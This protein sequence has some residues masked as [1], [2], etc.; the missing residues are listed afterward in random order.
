MEQHI[1][2]LQELKKYGVE[3][4]FRVREAERRPE[5]IT[6]VLDKIAS[7]QGHAGSGP[8]IEK[9]HTM[10]PSRPGGCERVDP[11]GIGA[12]A[13][14]FVPNQPRRR[15]QLFG[16]MEVSAGTKPGQHQAQRVCSHTQL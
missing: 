6:A 15:R 10:Q 5:V 13:S 14:S 9:H 8:E 3:I 4:E 16:D 11:S 2:K 1:G 7:V 12:T